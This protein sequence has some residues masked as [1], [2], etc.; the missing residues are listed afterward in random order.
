MGMYSLKKLNKIECKEQYCV[1]NSKR[2]TALDN[3]DVEVDINRAWETYV[4]EN[5]NISA[6]EKLG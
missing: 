2:F 4:R 3:L 5:I 6:K 1:E